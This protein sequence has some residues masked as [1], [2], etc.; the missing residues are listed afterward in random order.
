M[1]KK[2]KGGRVVE[3]LRAGK[4][5]PDREVVIFWRIGSDGEPMV[6]VRFA[7]M[8]GAETLAE[9]EK[10]CAVS[11]ETLGFRGAIP[12]SPCPGPVFVPVELAPHLLA[13]LNF[14]RGGERPW[15]AHKSTRRL[16]T[17][18]ALAWAAMLDAVPPEGGAN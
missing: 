3:R 10:L 15:L 5:D 6:L 18:G 13:L 2:T 12:G 7:I 17:D 11:F 1:S 9:P 16:L 4:P 8:P 14:A